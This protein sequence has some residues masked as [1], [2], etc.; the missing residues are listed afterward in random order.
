MISSA[1]PTSSTAISARNPARD[2]EP[3]ARL[4]TQAEIPAPRWALQTFQSSDFCDRV[5]RDVGTGL[6]L[7]LCHMTQLQSFLFEP[8]AKT[9]ASLPGRPRTRCDGQ[10]APLRG[11][12]A[13]VG[14]GEA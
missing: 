5:A 11:G 3:S 4:V 8:L 14:E 1:R 10:A 9:K 2:R 7:C 12:Q 13:V 6:L